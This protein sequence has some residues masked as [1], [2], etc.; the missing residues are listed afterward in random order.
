MEIDA[1]VDGVSNRQFDAVTSCGEDN[2]FWGDT[3]CA[4]TAMVF[5]TEYMGDEEESIA[6][7]ENVVSTYIRPFTFDELVIVILF[8]AFPQVAF[9]RY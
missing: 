9:A 8:F 4:I 5:G 7:D 2:L 1:T 3:S 6:S